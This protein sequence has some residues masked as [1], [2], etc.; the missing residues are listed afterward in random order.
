MVNPKFKKY[1]KN[2]ESGIKTN[3]YM[4]LVLYLD[5]NF[6]TLFSTCVEIRNDH[7]EPVS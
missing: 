2:Q 7:R 3:H 1:K 5:S 4:F 6:L